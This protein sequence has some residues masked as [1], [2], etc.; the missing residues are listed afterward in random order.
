MRMISYEEGC[1]PMYRVGSMQ[2]VI[3]VAQAAVHIKVFLPS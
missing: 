2:P 1:V 3:I